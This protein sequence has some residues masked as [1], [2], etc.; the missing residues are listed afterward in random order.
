MNTSRS[1][2][3]P[4]SSSSVCTALEVGGAGAVLPCFELAAELLVLALE[5]LAPPQQV[6][7]AVLRGRHEPGA[8]VVGDARLRATA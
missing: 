2:S 8:R 5:H 3:S 4:M 7:R 1:R 6:D